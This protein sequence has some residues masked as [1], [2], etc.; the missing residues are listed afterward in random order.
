MTCGYLFEMSHVGFKPPWDFISF[1]DEAIIRDGGNHSKH[2]SLRNGNVVHG[3]MRV[4]IRELE[5]LRPERE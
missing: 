4:V 2:V 5:M 3:R 1:S